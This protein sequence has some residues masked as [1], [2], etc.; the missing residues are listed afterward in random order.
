M[1]MSL[2]PEEYAIFVQLYHNGEYGKQRYGQAF[3]NH[4]CLHKISD[5]AVLGNLY[6]LDGNEAVKK[7]HSLFDLN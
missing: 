2:D 4:F 5:Q 1:R 7:I 3:Y 6:E